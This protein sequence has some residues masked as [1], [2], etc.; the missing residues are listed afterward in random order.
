MS[1]VEHATETSRDYIPVSA[2]AE[3]QQSRAS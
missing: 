2:R 3:Y 1:C